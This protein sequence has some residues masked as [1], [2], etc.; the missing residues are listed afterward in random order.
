MYN[1]FPQQTVTEQGAAK[2]SII[3]VKNGIFTRG[4]LMD[5]PSLLGKPYLEGGRAIYPEDLDAWEKKAGL[6][7]SSGDA[8]LIRTGRW[9][10][11]K[12]EGT[13]E[14][15]KNSSGLHA[16]CLP[17]LKKRDIAL[18][19]SDLASDVMPS[20]VEGV[21]MPVHQVI[22]NAMGV[23]ILDNGDFEELS[24]FAQNSKRWE[25]LLTVA[26]LAVDGGTG[27]PINPLAT[28]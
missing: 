28:Y 17:W 13:W 26:P 25:F 15:E 16:S 12:A 2:L 7:V 3:Q 14:I 18:L 10:R 22:L 23:P 11:R 4:I 1:G 24:K 9:A 5:I 21:T 19:G 20:Q 27:S 6:K 8:V